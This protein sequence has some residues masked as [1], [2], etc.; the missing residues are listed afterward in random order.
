M[1]TLYMW[2]GLIK[3]LWF[4]K[5]II[6]LPAFASVIHNKMLITEFR[7]YSNVADYVSFVKFY[8]SSY[9]SLIRFV[10]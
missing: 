2:Y 5:K 10:D 1:R 6:I 3:Y 8:N 4:K 9:A 7:S